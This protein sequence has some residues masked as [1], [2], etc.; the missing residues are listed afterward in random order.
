M[1]A[2]PRRFRHPRGAP[3]RLR[4]APRSRPRFSP[5]RRSPCRG[6]R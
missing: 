2:Q 4:V 6:R 1:R 3:H 5:R